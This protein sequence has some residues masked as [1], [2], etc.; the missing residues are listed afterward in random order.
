MTSHEWHKL[1]GHEIS[2]RI[3]SGTLHAV[4]LVE[5]LLARMSTI[6]SKLGAM[7]YI[8]YDGAL[9]QARQADQLAAAGSDLPLLGVPFT[10]KDNLWIE[11]RPATYGS[12][13]FA[14]F[15]A[16]RDSWSVARLKAA[17]AICI[18]ITNCSEFACKGITTNPLHGITRNPWQLDRTPGGSSGGAAASVAAG[19]SPIALGTDAGGSVRRPAAHTGLVGFKCT[20]GLIPN[21]WGF[22]EP[23]RDMGSIGTLTRNIADCALMMDILSGYD[24]RDPLSHPLPKE[25]IA[26]SAFA[27]ATTS[28]LDK[29]L[30]IAWSPDLG[31]DFAVDQDVA[32]EM[33]LAVDQLRKAGLSIDDASPQWSDDVISYPY[34]VRQHAELA[35]LFGTQWRADPSQFDPVIAAQIENGFAITATELT[36]ITFR[37][38]RAREQMNAFFERYDLL[39]CPTVPV[40]PWPCNVLAPGT[41]GGQKAG[42]RT[43]AVF[44]PLFNLCDV[45]AVSV[46]CGFG[47][48]GLPVAIQ[49]AGPRYA[50]LQV[51]QLGAEIE[52]ILSHDFNAPM[53]YSSPLEQNR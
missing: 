11:S 14:D 30:R 48:Q 4:D 46:P 10:V 44:T 42:P 21:P 33:Q 6:D 27:S 36:D 24:S 53:M 39:L 32:N 38:H 29:R 31:C 16:P 7:V 52:Q 20:S 17:G 41:I 22:D 19:F 23:C 40:E 43:H 28:A 5:Y 3:R 49:I 8:D 15:V 25:M 26:P 12:K 51:L 2:R 1:P 50:D 47:A 37:R 18:G 45:P 9:A 34:A 13:L 35:Q